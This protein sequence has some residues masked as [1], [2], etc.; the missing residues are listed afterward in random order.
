M[1]SLLEL[2][3]QVVRHNRVLQVAL[4]ERRIDLVLTLAVVPYGGADDYHD[5]PD[6]RV[7]LCQRVLQEVCRDVWPGLY[8]VRLQDVGLEVVAEHLTVVGARLQG[9]RVFPW[10][11]RLPVLFQGGV[12][13]ESVD[14][15]FSGQ[16]L[17]RQQ[18]LVVRVC[19]Q[20]PVFCQCF[21]RECFDPVHSVQW[22]A[23]QGHRK[24]V[25]WW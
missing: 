9:D 3:L 7:L 2:R 24:Q 23:W 6:G 25:F 4:Q 17:V 14:S 19:W 20:F 21:G 10:K 1:Q 11:Q 18:V 5:M 13:G 22:V 15:V 16:A 12:Q 8:P